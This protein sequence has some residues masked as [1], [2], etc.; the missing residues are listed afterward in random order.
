MRIGNSL[1]AG[2]MFVS[3]DLILQLVLLDTASIARRL[4][5][6]GRVLANLVFKVV[7]HESV[8]LR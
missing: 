1:H 2:E 8:T 4:R 3:R 5:R 7:W 6:P